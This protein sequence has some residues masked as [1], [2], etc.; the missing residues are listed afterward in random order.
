MLS[1]FANSRTIL[2]M[3]YKFFIFIFFFSCTPNVTKINNKV[4]LNSKGFALVYNDLDFQNKLIK[5]KLDNSKLQISHNSLS[6]STHIKI[7][8]PKTKDYIV[9]KNSKKINYPDFYKILISDEVA[10]K[11]NLN[12]DL[13]FVEILEIK[14]NKS[15]VAK[16][17]KIYNEERKISS[18]AP[19]AS[20][21][22]A[23]I[24]KNKKLKKIEKKESYFILIGSFYSKNV[25]KFLKREHQG[26]TEL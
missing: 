13:P 1:Q 8:N 11:L 4:P 18:N 16:K 10:K 24:S 7:I 15:F 17:A 22:I 14:K 20:V 25:A 26:N 6:L 23:N 2:E 5:G 12:K 9:L 19:V 3:K 21:E